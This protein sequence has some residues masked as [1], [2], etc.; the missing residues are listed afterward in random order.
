MKGK[1]VTF[2]GAPVQQEEE[3]ASFKAMKAAEAA[4][5]VAL[6]AEAE[7]KAVA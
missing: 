2:C 6:E 1:N 4:A 7:A 5:Q 3:L